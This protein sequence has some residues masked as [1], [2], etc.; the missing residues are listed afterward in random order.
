MSSGPTVA[1][2]NDAIFLIMSRLIS[3]SGIFFAF[4]FFESLSPVAHK[5]PPSTTERRRLVLVLAVFGEF[6]ADRSSTLSAGLLRHISLILPIG[7]DMVGWHNSRDNNTCMVAQGSRLSSVSGSKKKR[8]HVAQTATA[9][10][11]AHLP[12]AVKQTVRDGLQIDKHAEALLSPRVCLCTS[13]HLSECDWFRTVGS[14]CIKNGR[15][16]STTS[17][18]NTNKYV[19]QR[20]PTA[21]TRTS[22]WAASTTSTDST[23]K[24]VS[25]SGITS[26][27]RSRAI[28]VVNDSRSSA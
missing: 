21:R 13:L 12:P 28:I 26:F 19:S 9:A 16:A 1:S 25:R 24:D 3:L 18:D 5:S 17:A 7:D 10:A 22:G 27:C 23:N 15:A 6:P 8:D 20:V 2:T 4:P 11:R 14:G